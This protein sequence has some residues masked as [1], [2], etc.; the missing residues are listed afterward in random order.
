MTKSLINPKKKR[1]INSYLIKERKNINKD[2]KIK[3]SKR[4]RR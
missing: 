1:I 4:K 2:L 3:K